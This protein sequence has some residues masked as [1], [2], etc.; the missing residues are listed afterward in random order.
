MVFCEETN[1]WVPRHGRGSIKQVL[2]ERDVIRIVKPGD[3]VDPFK[4]SQIEKGIE[5]KKQKLRE[6]HNELRVKGVDTNKVAQMLSNKM[7]NKGK[8]VIK[9]K[10]S[11]LRRG[12]IG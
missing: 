5:K 9:K 8:K 11:G 12:V 2:A 7:G 1:D 10:V 6:M 4:K 3:V